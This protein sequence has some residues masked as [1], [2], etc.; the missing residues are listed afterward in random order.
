MASTEVFRYED[1]DTGDFL[2][3]RDRGGY[4][5]VDLSGVAVF[6][7]PADVVRLHNALGATIR[8]NGWSA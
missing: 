3:A 7:D 6:I 8:Q 1:K 5:S 2:S 4:L